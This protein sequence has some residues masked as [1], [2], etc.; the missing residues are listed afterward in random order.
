MSLRQRLV[1]CMHSLE[2]PPWRRCLQSIQHH[3]SRSVKLTVFSCSPCHFI[4]VISLS[5]LTRLLNVYLL[6]V[7]VLEAVSPSTNSQLHFYYAATMENWTSCFPSRFAWMVGNMVY[8]GELDLDGGDEP[9]LCNTHS[10]PLPGSAADPA[11]LSRTA[12]RP[13]SPSRV[14][15][16]PSPSG[17]TSTLAE[18][19]TLEAKQQLVSWAGGKSASSRR[20]L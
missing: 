7:P 4:F 14:A 13:V 10:L 3:Q 8:H 17:S 11:G 9:W 2:G 6:Q 1:T 5:T 20:L 15:H 12:P 16:G 19:D 18:L